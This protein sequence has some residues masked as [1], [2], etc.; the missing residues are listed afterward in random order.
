MTF[1]QSVV[2]IL[3]LS[4]LTTLCMFMLG[5]NND[6]GKLG[7][8]EEQLGSET[9]KLTFVIIAI[10]IFNFLLILGIYYL[11]RWILGTV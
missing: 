10:S 9:I 2:I 3:L 11:G 6:M 1:F 5:V 7:K 4:I 8:T